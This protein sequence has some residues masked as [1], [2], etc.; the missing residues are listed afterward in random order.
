MTLGAR[1]E[2]ETL[3]AERDYYPVSRDVLAELA[4][5]AAQPGAGRSR[6]GLEVLL[7]RTPDRREPGDR[8]ERGAA[9]RLD[10]GSRRE[11]PSAARQARYAADQ[12]R[13]RQYAIEAEALYDV[14]R[15]AAAVGRRE[16]M[17][18]APARG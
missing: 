8:A 2:A 4:G 14:A 12:V 5:V 6:A 7:Q 13:R 16:C 9:P 1:R 15:F 3:L 18:V 17:P 10:D 11:L